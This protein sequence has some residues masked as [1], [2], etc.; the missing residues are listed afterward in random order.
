MIRAYSKDFKNNIH[1]ASTGARAYIT[2]FWSQPPAAVQGAEPAV[3]SQRAKH[4]KA[5][6]VFVFKTVIG[7][8][9]AAVLH[10]MMYFVFLTSNVRI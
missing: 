6:E 8:G 5:D 4:L 7:N 2:G 9:S 1:I 3:G 10:E